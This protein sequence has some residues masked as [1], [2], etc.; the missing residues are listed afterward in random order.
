MK[1]SWYTEEQIISILREQEAGSSTADVC[2]KHGVS[3]ATFY[4]WRAT[5]GGMDVSQ[6]RKLKVLDDEKRPALRALQGM[7]ALIGEHGAVLKRGH[8]LGPI[9]AP[10]ERR[11]VKLVSGKIADLRRVLDPSD[12]GAFRR[13]FGLLMPRARSSKAAF[14]STSQRDIPEASIRSFRVRDNDQFIRNIQQYIRGTRSSPKNWHVKSLDRHGISC[15]HLLRQRPSILH[16]L[17]SNRHSILIRTDD[18]QGRVA[19]HI[20]LR[21]TDFRDGINVTF[22]SLFRRCATFFC[23]KGSFDQ[24]LNFLAIWPIITGKGYLIEVVG[25]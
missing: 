17:I 2:R 18:R 9:L 19:G 15:T 14:R 11:L 21:A 24:K 8:E 5:Y 7:W 23:G 4:K 16:H 25:G 10:I 22:N 3:S 1:R 20:H 6:A 12:L 13:H